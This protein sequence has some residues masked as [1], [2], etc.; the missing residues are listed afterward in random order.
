MNVHEKNKNGL[1]D[2]HWAAL[3]SQVAVVHLLVN[4][5]A[6]VDEKDNTGSSS[7]HKAVEIDMVRTMLEAGAS[8]DNQQN[9]GRIP[10]TFAAH[11]ENHKM[12]SILLEFDTNANY[13]MTTI[14]NGQLCILRK[15]LPL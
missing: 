5:E 15:L 1:S 12:V 9:D 14:I 8:I 13:C 10:L 2:L 6:N 4:A 7:L 3:K 11:F